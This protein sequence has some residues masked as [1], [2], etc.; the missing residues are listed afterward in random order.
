MRNGSLAKRSVSNF[1]ISCSRS[2]TGWSSGYLGRTRLRRPFSS[3]SLRA[4]CAR[5]T[6]QPSSRVGT[7]PKDAAAGFGGLPGRR[8]A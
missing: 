1:P 5:A 8:C 7:A 3:G 2:P 6:G 4:L